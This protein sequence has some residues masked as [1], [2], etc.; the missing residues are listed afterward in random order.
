[1]CV[2]IFTSWKSIGIWNLGFVLGHFNQISADAC[3]CMICGFGCGGLFRQQIK[4]IIRKNSWPCAG[5]WI[6]CDDKGSKRTTRSARMPG[7]SLKAEDW[8]FTLSAF[9]TKSVRTL[10]INSWMGA[11]NTINQKPSQLIKPSKAENLKTLSWLVLLISPATSTPQPQPS[12]LKFWRWTP[13]ASLLGSWKDGQ[14]TER[15]KTHCN[16]K[17]SGPRLLNLCMGYLICL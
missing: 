14:H 6:G 2:S 10:T 1:M 5:R 15:T 17:L 3:G 8:Q 11:L 13:R 7:L 16:L 12:W 9:C 4:K